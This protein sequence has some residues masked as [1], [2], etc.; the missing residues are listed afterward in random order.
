MVFHCQPKQLYEFKHASDY[1]ITENWNKNSRDK[2]IEA[3]KLQVSNSGEPILGTYRSTIKVY[4]YYDSVTHIDSMFDMEGNFVAG[5][6]RKPNRQSYALWKRTVNR[7]RKINW[8]I[9]SQ[10]SF[11]R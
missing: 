2:F 9:I 5:C 1:G 3:I 8:K 11:L 4:H 10:E 6:G 7:G